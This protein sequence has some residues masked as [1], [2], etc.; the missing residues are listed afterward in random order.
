M[1]QK[2]LSFI[3]I[4]IVSVCGTSY[5]H[6]ERQSTFHIPTFEFAPDFEVDGLSYKIIDG[7]V[8]LTRPAGSSET[9]PTY[10]LETLVVPETVSHGGNTYPVVR[11]GEG[12]FLEDKAIRNITIPE[13]VVSYGKYSFG[14]SGI[15]NVNFPS[16]LKK[17]EYMAFWF[18]ENLE[19]IVIPD[20]VEEIGESAFSACENM[21]TFTFGRG[22][23]SVGM[24]VVGSYSW[25]VHDPMGW[26]MGLEKNCTSTEL[27]HL[28]CPYD[29][30]PN[31]PDLASFWT[32]AGGYSYYLYFECRLMVPKGCKEKYKKHD[33]WKV[34][35]KISEDSSL[36]AIDD[37]A[38]DGEGIRV[39]GGRIVGEDVMEVYDLG[40]RQVARGTAEELPELPAGFYIVRNQTSTA[41]IA[42]R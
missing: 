6:A 29:T 19:S 40:G 14:Y 37:I 32:N 24:N 33:S 17:I 22:L 36:S 12:T 39:E 18:C 34:F 28:Y 8:E 11:I 10:N 15:K 23:A 21:R 20:N 13:G 25:L 1:K 41:K 35:E 38:V 16:T 26:G 9:V 4:L 5:V 31:F 30:P 3:L 2:F 7:G 27:T 42:I